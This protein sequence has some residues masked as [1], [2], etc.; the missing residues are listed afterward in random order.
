MFIIYFI[1]IMSEFFSINMDLIENY[2]KSDVGVGD[3]RPMPIENMDEFKNL[4]KASSKKTEGY[5]VEKRQS[6]IQ[7]LSTAINDNRESF[8]E[9][10]NNKN[11]SYDD[12]NYYRMRYY[13]TLALAQ[14]NEQ[15]LND[16]TCDDAEIMAF[17][18]QFNE[19]LTM[20][21]GNKQSGG[22][23]QEFA[24]M[25]LHILSN[26][27]YVSA[28]INDLSACFQKVIAY[29]VSGKILEKLKETDEQGG[30]KIFSGLVDVGVDITESI[31]K[32]DNKYVDEKINNIRE[33]FNEINNL[34]IELEKETDNE[35]KEEKEQEKMKEIAEKNEKIDDL[36]EFIELMKKGLKGSE[37]HAATMEIVEKAQADTDAAIRETID[38]ETDAAIEKTNKLVK[39]TEAL[40]KLA[41][42][43]RSLRVAVKNAKE[44]AN[45]AEKA[46]E[47][48]EE[49]RLEKETA[50]G[51]RKT[52]KNKKKMTKSKK[53]FK[54]Q[55]R[56]ILK[57]LSKKKKG[58]KH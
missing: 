6:L 25:I 50:G 45:D 23:G 55:S 20:S 19:E 7:K 32:I 9:F 44:A 10:V 54:K 48:D 17:I 2:V 51:K 21:G 53:H 46:A 4:L 36:V 40:K 13:I 37:E 29:M 22:N 3:K 16:D 33:G 28:K 8:E 34:F 38:K 42:A 1:Y 52:K 12:R 14:V 24:T 31:K 58:K 26:S 15:E 49:E 47:N 43:R 27:D 18:K 5:D 35:K 41:E 39:R 56:K 30:L 57:K 11:T